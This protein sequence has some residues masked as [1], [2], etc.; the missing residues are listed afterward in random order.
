MYIKVFTGLFPNHY[1][2]FSGF[3]PVISLLFTP[4]WKIPGQQQGGI[5][6]WN[7]DWGVSLFDF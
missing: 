2:A 3:Y 5:G 1:T 4:L 7:M 6:R